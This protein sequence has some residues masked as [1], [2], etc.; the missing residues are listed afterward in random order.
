MKR[1][2]VI[3]L[4]TIIAAL[5]QINAY[6]DFCLFTGIAGACNFNSLSSNSSPHTFFHC[7]ADNS[8]Y[9]K[10]F[11][12]NVLVGGFGPGAGTLT[13]TGSEIQKVLSNYYFEVAYDP[14]HKGLLQYIAATSVGPVR[15]KLGTG[16][17]P[18]VFPGAFAISAG[19]L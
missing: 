6:A 5:I 8:V 1:T 13:L 4:S 15:C 12:H 3:F 18:A 9:L 10:I 2:S 11:T 17:R 14:K 19:A 7:D 16:G